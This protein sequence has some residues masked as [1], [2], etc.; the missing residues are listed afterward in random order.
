MAEEE[1]RDWDDCRRERV[2]VRLART[3]DRKVAAERI[4]EPLSQSKVRGLSV[5]ARADHLMPGA[6]SGR[7][8]AVG[9]LVTASDVFSDQEGT[10]ASKCPRGPRPPRWPEL[11]RAAA[12][13]GGVC[14]HGCTVSSDAVHFFALLSSLLFP[15]S[16]SN[17]QK[18]HHDAAKVLFFAALAGERSERSISP[19]QVL[20]LDETGQLRL[21]S[22]EMED[23]EGA[24]AGAGGQVHARD[25][26]VGC[27]LRSRAAARGPQRTE[28]WRAT[29][30]HKRGAS[31]EHVQ[32]ESND[33]RQSFKVRRG[34]FGLG[35]G[36][37]RHCR[38]CPERTQC[39]VGPGNDA[40]GCREETG[41]EA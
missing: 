39:R 4:S 24:Q 7:M 2:E 19:A 25:V 22:E 29:T 8:P 30:F 36:K 21:L 32:R 37:A 23:V 6:E 10:A 38:Q 13:A 1:T 9:L 26:L 15:L 14:V 41:G 35:S 28:P 33:Q 17:P 20:G 27:S 18:S 11:A 31:V 34:L 40:R 5:L 16:S 12:R 3:W